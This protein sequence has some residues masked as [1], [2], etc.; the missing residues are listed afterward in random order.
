EPLRRTA[1]TVDLPE[2]IDA[3]ALPEI[4]EIDEV[5]YMKPDA[6]RL[7]VSPADATPS[8]PC[9]AQP[10]EIDIAY[11]A[12]YLEEA[13]TVPV[14]HIAHRWAGLRSFAPDKAPVVGLSG[15]ANGFFWLAG[16][17]GFGIQTSPALGELAASLILAGDVPDRFRS[18]GIS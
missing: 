7:M 9:D 10:E 14:S 4:C 5:F 18:A 6:G 15:K 16:Q 12:W 11:A 2:G 1:I 8:E 3:A 13:T 17:G